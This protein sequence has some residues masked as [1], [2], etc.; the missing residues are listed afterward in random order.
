VNNLLYKELPERITRKN[1]FDRDTIIVYN[2]IP[3]T[4]ST[5]FVNVAYD[6]CKRNGFSVLH[7]NVT[8]NLHV[9]SIAD[10]V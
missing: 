10:Q 9:M 4:A 8:G 7:L 1:S 5:S 3:K 6:L 2:R